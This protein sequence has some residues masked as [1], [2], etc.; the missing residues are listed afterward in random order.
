M[1]QPAAAAGSEPGYRRPIVVVQADRFNPGRIRT[2]I[3]VVITSNLDLAAAPRNVRLRSEDSGLSRPSVINVSQIFTLDCES[4][5][6]P[7]TTLPNRVVNQV[8]EGLRLVL[9]L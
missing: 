3:V 9:A 1:G 2:M 4:L 7:V 6:Q 8:A 5:A